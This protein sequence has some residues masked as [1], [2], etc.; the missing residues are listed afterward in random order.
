MHRGS[1][2]PSSSR[3]ALD[4]I[5]FRLLARGVLE[6]LKHM[7]ARGFVHRAMSP[8]SV[9]VDGIGDSPPPPPS[10]SYS[11]SYSSRSASPLHEGQGLTRVGEL[12]SCKY[13]GD[14]AGV[15]RKE[16]DQAKKYEEKK[17]RMKSQPYKRRRSSSSS[18]SSSSR[19][20]TM[21]DRHAASLKDKATRQLRS[22]DLESYIYKA[23]ELIL[24][25]KVRALLALA[26]VVALRLR[27]AV[28]MFVVCVVA[29]GRAN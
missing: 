19:N 17:R 3:G 12:G 5:D 20:L 8:S 21:W 1:S 23:P 24:G 29:I 25:S 4:Q 27:T 16:A 2:Q 6:A 26:W 15:L 18:S 14:I 10:S 9:F 22:R 28:M 7:H 13:F 11:S